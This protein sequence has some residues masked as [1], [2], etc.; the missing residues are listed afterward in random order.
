MILIHLTKTW[1]SIL[2]LKFMVKLLL[3]IVA[4]LPQI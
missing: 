1:N 3:F 2:I 4:V